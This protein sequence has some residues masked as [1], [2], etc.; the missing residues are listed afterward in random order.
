LDA[1]RWPKRQRPSRRCC[2]AGQ[3]FAESS[4]CDSSGYSYQPV[5]AKEPNTTSLKLWVF[6]VCP[7]VLLIFGFGAA[8][9]TTGFMVGGS[10]TPVVGAVIPALISAFSAGAAVFFQSQRAKEDEQER[11]KNRKPFGWLG[12][13]MLIF[14]A[15]Y[16][17][18]LYLGIQARTTYWGVGRISLPKDIRD[19]VNQAQITTQALLRLDLYHVLQKEGFSDSEAAKLV[20]KLITD[21]QSGIHAPSPMLTPSPDTFSAWPEVKQHLSPTP[22]PIEG[23]Q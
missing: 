21:P 10:T 14:F 13:I 11:Y 9:F 12:A 4:S 5:R 8:D 23:L 22:P 19:Q 6:R 7:P 18:G 15:L 20:R 2:R 16:F 1:R 17:P 3:T